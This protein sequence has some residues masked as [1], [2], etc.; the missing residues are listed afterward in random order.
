ME[1]ES[2]IRLP[3]EVGPAVEETADSVYL[4]LPLRRTE[5]RRP[6]SSPDR[7]LEE[8][9]R[10]MKYRIYLPKD[11]C[12]YLYHLPVRVRMTGL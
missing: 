9:A 10:G 5:A 7:E 1:Q 4:V 11:R 8:V 12:C 6:A 2:G 3:A